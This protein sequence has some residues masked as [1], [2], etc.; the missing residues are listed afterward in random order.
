[1][2][3]TLDLIGVTLLWLMLAAGTLWW[4]HRLRRG[5]P[6]WSV[7]EGLVSVL[8]MLWCSSMGA[9][10]FVRVAIGT[11]TPEGDLPMTPAVLGTG[12]GGLL[13]VAFIR[14]RT[15]WRGLGAVR[16]HRRWLLWAGAAVPGFLGVSM[17][18]GLL[19]QSLGVEPQQD[20]SAAVLGSWPSLE[21]SL[22]VGYGVLVA[23]LVEELLFRGFLLPPLARRLGGRAGVAV[24]ATLFGMMHFSDPQAV[25]PLIIMGAMLGALRL[26]SGSLWPALLLHVGNNAVAFVL[27]VASLEA[28]G[29]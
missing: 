4:S 26:A 25:P 18:W 28:G 13:T 5:G 15:D 10:I 27:L 16:C 23:P 19:L 24:S 29:G 3:V 11:W 9:L 2:T 1:M 20:I 22:M 14:A 21:A 7:A 8:V 17:I 12:V 6:D